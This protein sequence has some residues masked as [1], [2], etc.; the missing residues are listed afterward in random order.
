M[1]NIKSIATKTAAK[2]KVLW[3]QTTVAVAAFLVSATGCESGG[4]KG[5]SKDHEDR[6]A[7]VI[8]MVCTDSRASSIA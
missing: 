2:S 4:L 3:K 7:V 6:T 8:C 5:C 1:G